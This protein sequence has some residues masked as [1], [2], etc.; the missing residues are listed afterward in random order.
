MAVLLFPLF[1][2]S[3]LL[4]V[5]F[6]VSDGAK[7]DKITTYGWRRPR[8]YNLRSDNER[9]GRKRTAFLFLFFISFPPC[10]FFPSFSFLFLLFL[11]FLLFL[12][13]H[14]FPLH[15]WA[16]KDGW[17]RREKERDER[18]RQK[19][20]G[21]ER[22]T[23]RRGKKSSGVLVPAR[24]L[25]EQFWLGK[26]LCEFY[27]F[28]PFRC[29]FLLF[30]IFPALLLFFMLSTTLLFSVTP[31]SLIFLSSR[32]RLPESGNGKNIER[33]LK[34][35]PQEKKVSMI[36]LGEE[37]LQRHGEKQHRR[38]HRSRSLLGKLILP[39]ISAAIGAGISWC[40]GCNEHEEPPLVAQQNLAMTNQSVPPSGAGLLTKLTNWTVTVFS[41]NGMQ[42][43]NGNIMVP[44]TGL[45]QVIAE[46][47]WSTVTG[48]CSGGDQQAH[49]ESF[50]VVNDR[51]ALPAAHNDFT[52]N[53][54]CE[55]AN[56]I[57]TV[58]ALTA[59]DFVSIYVSHNANAN[60]VQLG[61]IPIGASGELSL[62]RFSVY[63]IPGSVC[64]C[65]WMKNAKTFLALSRHLMAQ[66]DHL[67]S[68]RGRYVSH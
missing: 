50:V 12:S 68:V 57:V 52:A 35:S 59:G 37:K 36:A 51:T 13:L 34:E 29:S 66:N 63:R 31:V 19:K 2:S 67:L 39:G 40:L 25:W 49:H 53:F 22:E 45:Y 14:P 7:R 26:F 16:I 11:R 4:S 61:P 60:A 17:G 55:L 32:N 47:G 58:V 65:W 3:F 64:P 5:S 41:L 20:E 43:S 15:D 6:R 62:P 1:I 27:I 38:H 9:R 10:H 54:A 23:K 56:N 30:S 44:E 21:R 18:A 8:I 42:Y 48:N 28:R 24:F 46:L 33:I